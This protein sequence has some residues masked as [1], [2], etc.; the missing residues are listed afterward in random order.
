VQSEW[1]LDSTQAKLVARREAL[2]IAADS[3]T[4]QERE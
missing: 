4:V 1:G 2:Y 3:V